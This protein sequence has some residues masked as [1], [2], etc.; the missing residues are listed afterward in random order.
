MEGK[1][2]MRYYQIIVILGFRNEVQNY[3]DR[4]NTYLIRREKKV[5]ADEN[6]ARRQR[7][8]DV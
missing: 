5:E 1:V 4:V 8:L 7:N 3:E 6:H 2:I